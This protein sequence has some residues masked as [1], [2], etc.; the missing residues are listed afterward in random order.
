LCLPAIFWKL[1]LLKNPPEVSDILSVFEVSSFGMI[2]FQ[3]CCKLAGIFWRCGFFH[4]A[5]LA[6]LLRCEEIAPDDG[7]N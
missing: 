4:F 2:S 3:K 1:S 5:L 7:V 6:S